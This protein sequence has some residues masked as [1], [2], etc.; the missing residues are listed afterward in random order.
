MNLY[1][2]KQQIN[3]SYP[4]LFSIIK[5][6][7]RARTHHRSVGVYLHRQEHS[8]FYEPFTL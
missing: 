1:K 6:D 2:L 3:Q 4:E 7:L 8:Y 5:S